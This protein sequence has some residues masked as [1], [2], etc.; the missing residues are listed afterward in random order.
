MFENIN[1]EYSTCL[2]EGEKETYDTYMIKNDKFYDIIKGGFEGKKLPIPRNYDEVLTNNFGDYMTLPPI[3]EQKPHHGILQL[4]FDT[5]QAKVEKKEAKS[6]ES[7]IVKLFL[8]IMGD[9]KYHIKEKIQKLGG[10]NNNNYKIKTNIKNFVF[11]LPG[12]GSNESVNR[13]SE[14]FNARIAYEIGLD[15]KTIYFDKQ[16]GLKISKYI[17]DAETLTVTSA[18]REDNMELMAYAL[19]ILHESKSV[20]YQEFKP[21][22]E[23]KEYKKTIIREE[24]SLL[25]N[26]QELDMTI[27]FL[28]D[29]LEKLEIDYVPCHLDAWP[30]NFVK[31]KDK[32]YLIDWEYSSN[33]DRLWDVV[34]IGLECEYPSEEE[35]LFY[36][37]Y[38]GR[39]PSS[40]EILKMDILRILMDLYWS[41]WSLAKVSCGEKDLYDYSMGRYERAI[42]N[43]NKFKKTSGYQ[44]RVCLE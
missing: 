31:S 39:K 17:K 23:I 20:F 35:D 14:Q 10:M 6:L 1:T 29:K 5:N 42:S 4:N 19:N 15:C 11:R 26:Y 41:M 9:H 21:F 28:K 2:A 43:L 27:N 33:Y 3:E 24:K 12:K 30:E 22:N 18:K 38:F 37:K 32:I 44:S 40:Q 16:S 8:E 13:D 7:D 34:S 36:H 25:E